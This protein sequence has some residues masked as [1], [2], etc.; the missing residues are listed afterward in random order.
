[1]LSRLTAAVAAIG[2]LISAQAAAQNFTAKDVENFIAVSKELQAIAA[3][4]DEG[5]LPAFDAFGGGNPMAMGA[6]GEMPS[7]FN[8]EGDLDIYSRFLAA[9]P[10]GPFKSDVTKTVK[11]N[12][13]ASLAAFG[14]VADDIILTMIAS[15]IT[16]QD[17]A[18]FE[19]TMAMM[20]PAYA[21]QLA[22]VKQIMEAAGNVSAQ[23]KATF[24]PYKDEFDDL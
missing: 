24:A 11:S 7:L 19:Q 21:S 16:A 1:M 13:F 2:L 4:Y 20:P 12:G 5:D 3:K 6:Q 9:L 18:D 17:L 15:E 10:G 22:P 14:D 23:D 8:A